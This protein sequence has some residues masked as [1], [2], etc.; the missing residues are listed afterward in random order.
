MRWII[1]LVFC[2]NAYALDTTIPEEFYRDNVF[3]YDS[4]MVLET[5]KENDTVKDTSDLLS[6]DEQFV[7]RHETFD[8]DGTS[9]QVDG[10]FFNWN[11]KKGVSVTPLFN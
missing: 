6:K 9:P 7:Y 10:A 4:A 5:I 8:T 3:T 2:S 11:N 1:T